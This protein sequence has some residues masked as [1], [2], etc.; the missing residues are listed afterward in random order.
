MTFPRI[1]KELEGQLV[2]MEV[3]GGDLDKDRGAAFGPQGTL[4]KKA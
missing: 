4:S 1:V 3:A 2:S